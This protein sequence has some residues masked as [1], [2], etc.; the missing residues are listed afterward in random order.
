MKQLVV[1]E[2][3]LD[4]HRLPDFLPLLTPLAQQIFTGLGFE[5]DFD[6]LSKRHGLQDKKT[7]TLQEIGHFY[8]V[9][10]ERIRQIEQR[11]LETLRKTIFG[12]NPKVKMPTEFVEL[13]QRFKIE[14]HQIGPVITL[15]EVVE[16]VQLISNITF[17]HEDL[18]ALHLLL[19]L[20]SFERLRENVYRPDVSAVSSWLTD[21]RIGKVDL[22]DT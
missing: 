7:Y 16:K 8:G 3:N 21:N 11:A 9:E 18:P 1:L 19:S 14:L 22:F 20:Y 12:E 17:I 6:I 5:R 10:R 4:W 2:P 15:R 13:T